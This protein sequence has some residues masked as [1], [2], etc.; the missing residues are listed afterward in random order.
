MIRIFHK[1]SDR[2][3]HFWG[4]GQAK[5]RPADIINHAKQYYFAGDRCSENRLESSA[6]QSLPY[7]ALTNYSFACELYFKA[8]YKHITKSNIKGHN[9]RMLFDKLPGHWR[10]KI[11]AEYRKRY[12]TMTTW[13]LSEALSIKIGESSEMII[14]KEAPALPRLLQA[15]G[16]TFEDSRYNFEN[17]KGYYNEIGLEAL[18]SACFS[19]GEELM[20]E[21]SNPTQS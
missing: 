2:A 8:F 1:E 9:L 16:Q 6:T 3:F 18:A 20:S 15:I 11:G 5:N 7:A 21:I 19:I 13:I 12:S 4:T 10:D 14:S 17:T